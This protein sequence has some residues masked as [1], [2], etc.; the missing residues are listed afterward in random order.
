[1][2]ENASPAGLAVAAAVGS[3]LAVLPLISLHT[4]VI[5]YVASR[6]HLN[7]V[8]AVSIQHLYMPPFIPLLC[9]ELGYY[10][11]NG[12]WLTEV[13]KQT[14][15]AELPHRLYEWLLGSILIA[16]LAAVLMG[17]V[18]FSLARVLHRSGRSRGK[19]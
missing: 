15:V 10:F 16:P 14:L 3:F 17:L 6:L 1:L 2:R 4:V 19:T 11:R 12:H 8:M 13:S 9:I 5:L 18:V 7:K